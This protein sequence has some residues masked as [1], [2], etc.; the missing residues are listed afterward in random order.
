MRAN[1]EHNLNDTTERQPEALSYEAQFSALQ[2]R[3]LGSVRMVAALGKKSAE[4]R[5]NVQLKDVPGTQPILPRLNSLQPAFTAC[6]LLGGRLCF[7]CVYILS[8]QGWISV[9]YGKAQVSTQMSMKLLKR[10]DGAGGGK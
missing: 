10:R 1:L 6:T 3:D 7:C 9:G 8:Q 5:R 4:P 2:R